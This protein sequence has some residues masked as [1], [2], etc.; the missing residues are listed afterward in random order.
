MAVVLPTI[1]QKFTRVEASRARHLGGTGLG[2]SI[3]TAIAHAHN[4]RLVA[5]NHPEGGLEIILS[6]PQS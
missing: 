3:A 2:L 4:G 1:F 5:R 6:L